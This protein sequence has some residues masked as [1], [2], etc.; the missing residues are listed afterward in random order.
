MN[1][2]RRGTIENY[3][4][5][6]H[7]VTIGMLQQLC[8]DVSLMTIH[9]D[10]NVLE[11]A[12]KIMKI[13]GGAVWVQHDKDPVFEERLRENMTG[14]EQIA[15]K[16][17]AF[18]SGKGSVFLDSG[19]TCLKIARGL[20]EG[21][22]PVFTTAPHIALELAKLERPQ[23]VLC[24]GVLSRR[25]LALS[26]PNTLRFLEEVN[27]D[28]AFLGVSGAMADAGFTCGSDEDRQ[29]KQCVLRRAATRILVCDKTKFSRRMPFTFAYFSDIDILISD[30]AVPADIRAAAEANGVKI[31]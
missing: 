11:E 31:L 27:L 15:Q 29:V 26:G 13:R 8:P 5:E 14:K 23:I 2:F 24:G 1:R 10:L 19:T 3:I 9:R 16:A 30:D 18:I 20:P 25:N 6:H 7:E 28:V 22:Y 17:L 21:D 4:R 12:G